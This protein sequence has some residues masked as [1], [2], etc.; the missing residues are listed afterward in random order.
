[1]TTVRSPA[2]IVLIVL[3]FAAGCSIPQAPA[4]P[5]ALFETLGPPVA[6]AQFDASGG[7][8]GVKE[9]PTLVKNDAGWRRVLTPAQFDVLRRGVTELPDP[10]ADR[11]PFPGG[12]YRCAGCGTALFDSRDRFVSGSGW[13][14]FWQPIAPQNIESRWDH[15]WEVRRRQVLCRR[16]GGALGH[17]FKDGPPP[18]YLRY[19]INPSALSEAGTHRANPVP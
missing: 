1:M 4:P 6:I 11:P 9:M 3:A 2:A 5:E 17:V 8:L 7:P 16:C 18:S 15:S 13:P 14:S 19:C 12:V 10:A